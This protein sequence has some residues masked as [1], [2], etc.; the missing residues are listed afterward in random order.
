MP[1]LNQIIQLFKKFAF[2]LLLTFSFQAT[3]QNTLSDTKVDSLLHVLRLPAL[4]SIVLITEKATL[5]SL[6]FFGIKKNRGEIKSATLV[7]L[8]QKI[9]KLASEN[10]NSGLEMYVG[11]WKYYIESKNYNSNY[12]FNKSLEKIVKKA[13]N[14]G[15]LWHETTAKFKYAYW[16][17]KPKQE[18]KNIEKGI[19][20]LRE[21]IE[22]IHK[23]NDASISPGSLLEHYRVLTGCYYEMDDIPNAI[24]YSVKALNMDYPKGSKLI[25]PKDR[26][27]RS[28]NNNLGVYYRENQQLD[29]STFYFKRVF[30]LP[31]TNNSSRGDSLIHAISGGNLGENL[32]LQGNYKEALPLLQ[33][34]ADFTTKA[35]YWGNASNALILIADIHLK[36]GELK[37]AKEVLDKATFAA[38]HSSKKIK[39]LI[40]LYPLA[41]KYYKAIDQPSIALAYAD[42]TIVGLDSLKSK[43]NQFRG[44][45]VEQSYNKHQLKR[46]SDEQRKRLKADAERKLINKNSNIR[47]RNIGIFCLILLLGIGY[48]VF[49]K[50][51]VK[52]KQSEIVLTNKVEQ[53]SEELS[54]KEKELKNKIQE[55]EAKKSVINWSDLKI[56]SDEQWDQFLE[57]FQKEHPNFIVNI[58]SKFTSITAGEL[59]LLCLTRV[60]LNDAVMASMLGVNVNSIS[61]TRRR[62]MRKSKIENLTNLKELIFN[63]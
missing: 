50:F 26:A 37:K 23:K 62:F 28:I 18:F 36:K 49:R 61:Q 30:N 58:K 16:L 42:S 21:N 27:Y 40:K 60:G 34:D 7:K 54:S 35:K 56:Y 48:F 22:K 11:L 33:R 59:R 10:K 14:S 17:T 45:N 39:R 5:S 20:L 57:V 53:V 3:A 47:K 15:V 19:W 29:S 55:I 52:S 2:V 46:D 31:L 1:R 4:D 32:Y 41:S 63:I 38:H 8:F 51:K 25:S 9:E 12:E 44:A 6:Y 43:N 13:T 24:I